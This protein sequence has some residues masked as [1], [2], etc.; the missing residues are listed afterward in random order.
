VPIKCIGHKNLPIPIVSKSPIIGRTNRR[1]PIIGQY[2][3]L[4]IDQYTASWQYLLCS[5]WSVLFSVSAAESR[6]WTE[7]ATAS[8]R[9]TRWHPH[10]CRWHRQWPNGGTVSAALMLIYLMLFV[11]DILV[12]SLQKTSF[13]MAV[14]LF[15]ISILVL[16]RLGVLQVDSCLKKH[17]WG[18][19]WQELCKYNTISGFNN[20]VF[21]AVKNTQDSNTLV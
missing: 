2:Q 7:V 9:P 15:G 11:L 13:F 18:L 3:L 5:D 17:F 8:E 20:L 19:C 4:P 14:F 1:I 10:Y 16:P 21:E 12:G 6:E